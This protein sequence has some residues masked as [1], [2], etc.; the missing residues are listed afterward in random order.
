MG[1]PAYIV[2]FSD[3]ITLLL[4]FFVLLLSLAKTQD[5]GLFKKGQNSFKR[6]VAD[7]G[8]SGM[9]FSKNAGSEFDYPRIK[10]KIEKGDDQ[11]EDRSVDSTAEVLSRIINEIENSMEVSPPQIVAES[12][13]FDVTDITFSPGSTSLNADSAK[14]IEEYIN[15]IRE[16]FASE[17]PSFYVVGICNTEKTDQNQWVAS[18]R[19]AQAVADRMKKLLGPDNDWP[20]Y[21]WG[22]GPGGDWT[23]QNGLV[24]EKTQILIAA[25]TPR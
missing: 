25:L 20:I 18:A 10:Y 14:Y 3:M 7:F 12:K 15:R 4:T 1:A 21:S 22:A 2:T 8:M 23:S 19:R 5:K 13:T 6:A 17:H 24:S 11:P 9:L 16:A